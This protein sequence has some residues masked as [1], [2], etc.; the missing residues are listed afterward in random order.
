MQE[1]LA[2]LNDEQFVLFVTGLFAST[3][4]VMGQLVALV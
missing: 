3:S 2:E 4:I 1:A